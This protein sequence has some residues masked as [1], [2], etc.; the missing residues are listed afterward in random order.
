M[1]TNANLQSARTARDDEFYTKYADVDAE[2][3]HYMPDL[4]GCRVYCGA[5]GPESMFVRWMLDHWDALELSGLT[6]TQFNPLAPPVRTRS[7]LRLDAARPES[8]RKR[9]VRR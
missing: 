9:F 6:A 4:K 1:V 5:D 3:S 8:G 7:A 2:L